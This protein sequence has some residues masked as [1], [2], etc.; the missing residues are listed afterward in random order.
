MNAEGRIEDTRL[1]SLAQAGDREAFG[2]IVQKHSRSLFALAFRVSGN[3]A[4]AD[5]VVQETFL[6]AF[7][8]LKNFESRSN[9]GTWLYRIAMNCA[10]DQKD[11]E[12]WNPKHAVAISEDPDP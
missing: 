11:R 10:L 4:D 8:G 7:R 2:Q 3:E 1:V 12:K 5:E 6:R 9:L